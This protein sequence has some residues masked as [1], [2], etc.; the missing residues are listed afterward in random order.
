MKKR[1]VVK[2]GSNVLT[3]DDGK[4]DVTRMSAIVDQIVTLRRN[5]YETILVS[6]GSI[7]SGHN[8]LKIDKKLGSVAQRQLYSAVGQVKLIS[9]YNELFREYNIPVGQILTDRKST[10]LNSSH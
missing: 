9:L 2:V 4:L 6:S 8:D 7:T 1:I 3:Q 5:G 10:R